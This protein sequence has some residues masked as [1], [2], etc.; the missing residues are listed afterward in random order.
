MDYK[1]TQ[2]GRLYND[3]HAQCCSPNPSKHAIG[4][5]L[6]V[7]SFISDHKNPSRV[8]GRC[9]NCLLK[10]NR[11]SRRE[12][13][14][15]N[16]CQQCNLPA[17]F[18]SLCEWHWYRKKAGTTFK[19]DNRV[20]KYTTQECDALAVHIRSI[21]PK[22]G[23]CPYCGT[24]ITRRGGSL[25]DGIKASHWRNASLDAINPERGHVAGNLLWVCFSC[26]KIK[27]GSRI[28]YIRQRIER[29]RTIERFM[30]QQG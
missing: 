15:N 13:K 5:M 4:A 23:I 16:V 14:L 1:C 8:S 20:G 25:N 12:K 17:V 27:G 10:E 30:Q 6:T 18:H 11:R 26:N 2:K 29:L 28:G 7:D 3:T 21:Y 24:K 22:D 19:H 9:R